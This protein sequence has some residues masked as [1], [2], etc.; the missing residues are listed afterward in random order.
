MRFFALCCSLL[1]SISFAFTKHGCIGC[2]EG[3]L[4]SYESFKREFHPKRAF[5]LES[6]GLDD[7]KR[8]SVFA[9]NIRKI[10]LQNGLYAKGESSY[11]YGVNQF[12]D[13]TNEEFKKHILGEM[14]KHSEG[15]KA[16]SRIDETSS[17]SSIDWRKRGAVTPVKSQGSC[18]SCW[19]FSTTGALEGTIKV[20]TGTLVSLSESQLVDCSRPWGPHGCSGGWPYAAMKYVIDNG[21]ID[22]ESDYAYRPQNGQCDKTKQARHVAGIKGYKIVQKDSVSQLMAALNLAPVSITVD[23]G[24]FQ[25]YNGGVLDHNCGTALNHAVLAVGYTEVN[26]PTYPNSWI[27]KNSWGTWWGVNGYVYIGR[28]TASSPHGLCG[29]LIQSQYATGGWV[30][31]DNPV[32]MPTPAPTKP[33]PN[34]NPTPSPT[35]RDDNQSC[36]DW[37][38]HGECNRNPG[39]MLIH[40]QKSCNNCSACV[41]LNEFCHAWAENGECHRNYG[42]MLRN[43]KKS[44]NI[45]SAVRAPSSAPADTLVVTVKDRLAKAS[46]M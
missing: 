24:A 41:D 22:S 17:A 44:C 16:A 38:K 21:G 4:M 27:V 9:E 13:L 10:K 33:S 20:A 18:G 29:I 35:C 34:P 12:S 11:K 31:G 1:F 39:Y 19:S 30:A 40:C 26:D 25:H 2:L 37:A 14:P 28:S 5:K 8:S 3:D 43:C 42:Y 6:F 15:F 23:A 46:S 32:P 36:A 45:C 7:D